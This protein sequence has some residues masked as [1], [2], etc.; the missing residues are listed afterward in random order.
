MSTRDRRS[1]RLRR[2]LSA[3]AVPIA[4]AL[5]VQIGATNASWNDAE[6]TSAAFAAVDCDAPQGAFA[7]R[8][9]GRALSGSL[10]G[11]DLDTLAEASGVEVT[12]DGSRAQVAP[13][14]A[15]PATG[16]DAYANSLNVTALSA[17]NLDL[18][19][20]L[21]QLPLDSSTGVLGQFGQAQDSGVSAGA[22]GYVTDSGGMGLAQENGYPELATLELSRLLS[23]INPAVAGLLADVTD[24]S[25]EVG[26]VAGRATLE[27]CETAWS[28]TSALAESLTREYLVSSAE[29]VVTSPTVGTLATTLSGTVSSLQ[30][31]VN[32][33]Q[34][35]LKTTIASS[36]DALITPLL[37]LIS[38]SV[39]VDTLAL[40]IDLSDVS[41]LL[42]TTIADEDA[43]VSIDLPA[44]AITID[45]AALLGKAYGETG[46]ADLNGLAPNTN[47][48]SDPDILTT[49]TSAATDALADW[50]L[51]VQSALQAAIDDI[52]VQLDATIILGPLG[53]PLARIAVGLAAPLADLEN[54]DATVDATVL[55]IISTSLLNNVLSALTSG[56]GGLVSD[57]IHGALPTVASLTQTLNAPVAAVADVV[58]LVYSTLY[59]DGVVSLTVNA[60]NDPLA[61][62]A[63]PGDWAALPPGRYDVAALRIGVLA[64][65]G[66]SEVRLYLGRGSV[67][68]VCSLAQAPISCQ[69]Y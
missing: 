23:S 35:T 49:L 27:G 42:T 67:G 51:D 57:L 53:L 48:F 14:G 18:G 16:D 61:G 2:A 56:V 17:V 11:V 40:T 68:R 38:S 45:T 25:L 29:T 9:E 22:G 59:L 55:G 19:N 1:V 46:R 50:V 34:T 58:T 20:G 26:A 28:G 6:W 12:N 15:N 7:T 31:T 43:I 24:V 32:G 39:T 5:V 21:L 3:V 13:T 41:A 36:I 64:A 69:G 30:T 4:T 66:D 54:V 44:G 8:G 62:S 60:Q 65:A 10:L 33:L 47:L 52:Q 37:G 63:E